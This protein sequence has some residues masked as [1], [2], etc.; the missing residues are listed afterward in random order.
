MEE[1]KRILKP[2]GYLIARVSRVNDAYNIS[3]DDP[4]FRYH[5]YGSYG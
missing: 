3:N 2:G 1:I 4:D 5:D